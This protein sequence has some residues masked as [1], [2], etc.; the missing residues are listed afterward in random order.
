[1]Q[2]DLAWFGAV[3][4]ADLVFNLCEGVGGVSRLEVNVAYLMELAGI[5]FT[6][7]T[8]WTI[9]ACHRKPFLNAFLASRGVPVPRWHVPEGTVAV[10]DDFPLPAIVKPS[11]EDASIGI[12]QGSVVTSAAALRDR[13]AL[14]RERHGAAIVQQ[15]IAGREVAVGFVG[16][17]TLPLSEI[18]FSDLPAG[19]WPIVSF[20]AKWHE[21]S[22]EYAG[23]QP[24]CPAKVDADLT[25][26][27]VRVATTA[28]QAVE[29]RGYGRVDLRIDAE[30]NPWVLEVNPNPD[31]STDAGL[32]NMARAHGWTY[33]QLVL[34]ILEAAT[35]DQRRRQ[36]A[37]I[38]PRREV[39]LA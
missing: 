32:A 27:I 19:A 10:P 6:G 14:V 16:D 23:T 5:P 12:E 20:A 33:G 38:L 36:T 37:P 3:R 18:D 21:A 4:D 7:C 15:Y 28:W 34:R 17:L 24:V 13:V 30:G 26:R 31:L 1:M 35:H 2:P 9:A 29:G 39:S 11:A 25:D 8:A 22:P